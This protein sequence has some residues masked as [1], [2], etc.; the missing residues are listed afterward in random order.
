MLKLNAEVGV[1]LLSSQE[2]VYLYQIRM[3]FLWRCSLTGLLL[4]VTINALGQASKNRDDDAHQTDQHSD[5]APPQ[6]NTPSAPITNENPGY[7]SMGADPENRLLKPFL[8]HMVSDQEQFWTSPKQLRQPS[9]LRTFIPFVGFTGLLVATDSWL[10]KQIPDKPNQL[11]RSKN[12]SDYTTYSLIGAA[13][14]AYGFGLVTHNDHLRETGFLSG[15]AALD[16][17]V[18]AYAFKE[19]TQRQRPYQG[20]G[21][22]GFFVGGSSFP[23]EH[24]AVAWSVAST[25][26]HEYPGK[27]T[28][29]A[30][31][32]LA[33]LVTVTRVTAQQHFPADAFVGSALGWYFARQIYRA[34]HDTGL[35]GAGWGNFVEEKP[36]E[37]I[38]NVN[39]M[40]SP[41]VPLDSWIYPALQRLIAMGYVQSGVLGMRPWTRM[42]CARIL[43]DARDKFPDLG[44]EEVNGGK[45]YAALI[46]EFGAEISR[47]D[48]A[49]NVDARVESVYTR[50]LAISGTP[51]RDG[52]HF[53]QTII[54]DYGRP[55][56]NGVNNITGLSAEA[57]AGPVSLYFRGEYEYA[58]AMPSESQPTLSATA[59][60][61]FTAP[62]ANGAK[63]IDKFALLDSMASFDLDTT[64]I[65][66]GYQ[67]AWL[68]PGESGSLLLS[69][70]AEP[71]PM[72]RIDQTVPRNIPGLSRILGPFRAEFFV[73]Q[74][75]G[76]HWEECTSPTCPQSYPGYPNLVGPNISSQPFIHAEKI[77]FQPT[78]NFEF[79]M[80]ITAMF[81]GPGLPVTFR[82]FFHTYYVHTSN[83]AKNPGK[84]ISAADLTYRIPKM[85]NWLTFY[86]DSMV[87]DEISP[88]GSTRA[89]VNPGI[90][91]PQIPKVPRLE[92]RA[93]GV[94]ISRTHEFPPGF[95]YFNADRYRSGYVNNGNLLGSWIGRAG[96]GGQG[97]LTYWLSARN[98]IQLGYRLQTV[99]PA[100]IG[101]GHLTDYSARAEF[102]IGKNLSVSTFVQYEPWRFPA[103]VPTPQSNV[104]SAVQLMLF[105]DVRLGKSRST[106]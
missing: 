46:S 63:A 68:G 7:L 67:T 26:A 10:S 41:Y 21:H 11:S 81:G 78:P 32:G 102:M 22:G 101:G 88:I 1:L 45:T 91:L 36:G 97:W 84:R 60:V 50:I 38:R 3:A 71:F 37:K 93:E 27:L 14:G 28:Q 18:A 30:A 51:L 4:V 43:E 48:G 75:S 83:L 85:R 17:T 76:Q 29:I 56:W 72:A 70:N 77:S 25:F 62:L 39:Y 66:F 40:A 57:D 95:V 54:N 58:P 8:R 100:F 79:G 47:L 74:L 35:G 92:L 31:Y 20:N 65:S 99:S 61:D 80:G 106:P 16:S 104:T 103:L 87:W 19:I 24:S 52:Y 44:T 15:E 98:K 9:A 82:N 59:A 94:N 2:S 42:L 55:Y 5:T 73:G 86:L 105:P 89:N 6:A 53:G 49:P 13:A 12:I 23:S 69:N 33:S 64:Q 90:Y 34:H 96:R